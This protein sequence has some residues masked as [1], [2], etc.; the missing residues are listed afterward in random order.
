MDSI[1]ISMEKIKLEL[2]VAWP[3]TTRCQEL[4]NAAENAAKDFGDQVEVN[5]CYRGQPYR[6]EATLS[7]FRAIKTAKLPVLI[8]NG[9]IIEMENKPM[10]PE[11]KD[12]IKR[13]L[14]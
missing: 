3:P 6:H 13:K 10:E 2:L 14:V 9:E 5:L 4:I 1:V 8:V 12:A 11:I 7:L